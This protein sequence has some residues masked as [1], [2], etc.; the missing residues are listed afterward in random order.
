MATLSLLSSDNEHACAGSSNILY[1]G[2]A[3]HK[4][5]K[6]YLSVPVVPKQVPFSI[7]DI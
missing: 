4:Y 1:V 7:V 6:T 2:V 5:H 3:V